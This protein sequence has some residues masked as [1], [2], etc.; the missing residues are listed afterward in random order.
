[1]IA[2]TPAYIWTK[3]LPTASLR[4]N[5][6]FDGFYFVSWYKDW[7]SD[8]SE[9]QGVAYEFNALLYCYTRTLRPQRLPFPVNP[10]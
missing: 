7:R 1:M 2:D 4:H 10:T 6:T 3:H 8:I 9:G 5:K